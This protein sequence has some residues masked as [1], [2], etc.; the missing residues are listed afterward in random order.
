MRSGV[1]LGEGRGSVMKKLKGI[2]VEEFARLRALLD[3]GQPKADVLA[4][5]GLDV[6]RWEEAEE[7]W[8]VSLADDLESGEPAELQAFEVAYR[9][10]WAGPA[11]RA[12]TAVVAPFEPPREEP[13]GKPVAVSTAPLDTAM[14]LPQ[15]AL[16]F[17][18]GEEAPRAEADER[19]ASGRREQEVD[20]PL[21]PLS[22]QP[23][24]A[25]TLLPAEPLP[26]RRT[27]DGSS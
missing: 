8:L 1:P 11:P 9:G 25:V 18:R 21:N 7:E 20:E 13:H 5:V 27:R 14:F 23:F 16:P 2:S 17:R 15:E 19:Y 12:E 22:T 4:N 26:F 3:A 24:S 10:A 6:I